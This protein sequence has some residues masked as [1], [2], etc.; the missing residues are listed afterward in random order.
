MHQ[1][2]IS[3]TQ[4][5]SVM[6][7]SR[8]EGPKKKMWKLLEPSDENQTQ[9]HDIEP[10]PLK[11]RAM[12]EGDNPSFWDEF[13]KF[14]IFLTVEQSIDMDCFFLGTCKHAYD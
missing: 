4:G 14:T 11:N 7:R 5:S 3:T 9:C 6:L 13:T 12:P 10:N 8:V 1:M 2:R